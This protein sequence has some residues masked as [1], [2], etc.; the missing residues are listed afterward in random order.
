MKRMALHP[1]NSKRRCNSLSHCRV[2]SCFCRAKY[3]ALC[4]A[5]ESKIVKWRVL[6]LRQSVSHAG[7]CIPQLMA[8]CYL[9]QKNG[10]PL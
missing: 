9:A 3:A 2:V 7:H 10:T 5:N 4:V 8:K 6:P 1:Y